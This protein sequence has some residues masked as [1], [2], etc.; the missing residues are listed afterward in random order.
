MN[1]NTDDE[2]YDVSFSLPWTVH[3]ASTGQDAINIAVSE[4]GKVL[5]GLTDDFRN[6]EIEVQRSACGEC[7]SET[8]TLVVIAGK[9]LVGLILT[10]EVR[11]SSAE[12]SGQH[13]RR[14]LGKQLP[15]TPLTLVDAAG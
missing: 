1:T 9:A 13:A 4:L 14:V 15:D 12:T 5:A 7:G 10:A 3:N 11:A 2:W 8:Y 6:V